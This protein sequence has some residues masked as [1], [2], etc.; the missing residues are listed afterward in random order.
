MKT[1]NLILMAILIT[2]THLHENQTENW[3]QFLVGEWKPP[4]TIEYPNTIN[5]SKLNVNHFIPHK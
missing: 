3:C 4:N 2:N 1:F 5:I